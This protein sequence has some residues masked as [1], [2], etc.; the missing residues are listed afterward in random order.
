MLATRLHSL[1]SGAC[2]RASR[3][4]TCRSARDLSASIRRPALRSAASLIRGPTSCRLVTGTVLYS[5]ESE[6]PAQGFLRNS[7]QRCSACSKLAL[8]K[9]LC[10]RWIGIVGGND[11]KCWQSDKI[12]FFEDLMKSVLPLPLACGELAG[13]APG[14]KTLPRTIAALVLARTLILFRYFRSLIHAP[15]AARVFP[16]LLA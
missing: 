2:A 9:G 5:L 4:L 1:V 3:G 14:Y 13:T 12:N 8:P 7:L 6:S 15:A 16:S 11:L 10:C